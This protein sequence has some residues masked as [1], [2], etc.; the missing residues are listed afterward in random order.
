LE[1]EWQR[2]KSMPLIEK[3]ETKVRASYDEVLV[4]R[5]FCLGR[6]LLS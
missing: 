1:W 4:P 6:K 2:P 3:K 5:F